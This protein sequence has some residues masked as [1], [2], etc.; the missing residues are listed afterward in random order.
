MKFK[1]VK[2]LESILLEYGMKSGS[3]TPSGQ[4]QTGANAKA[5]KIKSPTTSNAPKKP[6]QGSPTVGDK[7]VPEPIE[8]QQQSAKDIKKDAVI[9]GQDNKNKKVVSPVGQGDLPDAM[10]VQDDDGEYEIIDQNE[11]V[12]AL[13]PED[14]EKIGKDPSLLAKGKGAFGAGAGAVDKI[15]NLM[16]S[17]DPNVKEGKIRKRINKKALNKLKPR[18]RQEKGRVKK[19]ARLGLTEAIEK[20]FEINFRNKDVINSSLDAQIRCGW[21]A[22]TVWENIS[23]PSDDID[24]LTLNEVDDQFGG[25]DWDGIS[26]SYTEWLYDNKVEE[27][28]DDLIQ[29]FINEREDDEDYINEFIEDEGIEE[30]DWDDYREGVLRTE[31]GDERFEEEGAEELSELYGY[32]DENWAREYVDEY[33][34]SDFREYLRN[35]AEEDDD[36]KQAAYEEASENYDY[37][38]WVN[39]SYYSMSEFCDNWDIDY[40]SGG[41]LEEVADKLEDWITDNSAFHDH[42]PDTGSYGDTSGNTT[43]YAVET[44]SSIDGYGTGAEIISPVFSTPR[45]MLKEMD[46]FFKFL[47]SEGVV[48]NNS[49]GLHITMSYFPQEGETVSHEDGKIEANKVKMAVLLGDQY[50]LSQWGRDRNTYTKSQLKELQSAIQNLKR[51]GRGTEAIKEAEKFLAKH[52]SEDKFRSIHFKGQTDQ[53][54]NTKLIEFRIGGGEDYHEEFKKV[55]S[56]VVRYATTMIAG[57]TDQYQGDY[58]KALLRLMNNMDKI[59]TSDE[60]EVENLKSQHSDY[61]GHPILDTH[62]AIISAKNYLD[63]TQKMLNAMEDLHKASL[64]LDPKADKKWKKEWVDFLKGTGSNLD[65]YDSKIRKALDKIP[66]KKITE[67]KDRDDRSIKAYMQPETTPPSERAI[68][69]RK[70]GLRKFSEAMGMLSIDISKKTARSKPNAKSIGAFR[71][72]LKDYDI[73]EKELDLNV[74][75]I[76]NDVNLGPDLKNTHKTKLEAIR[77]GINTLLQKDVITRPDYA[78]SPQ[79]EAMAKGLWNAFNDEQ[80]DDKTR[81][82]LIRLVISMRTGDISQGSVDDKEVKRDVAILI[83]QAKDKREFNDFYNTIV[84][85]PTSGGHERFLSPG[86]IFSKPDFDKLITY[87]KGFESYTQPVNRYHNPNLY[88]DDSYEENS[89]S[90]YTLLLRRRFEYLENQFD[91]D[92]SLATQSLERMSKLVETFYQENQSGQFEWPDIFGID[93]DELRSD[94]PTDPRVKKMSYEEKDTI[95]D[96]YGDNDGTPFLGINSYKVERVQGVLDNIARGDIDRR[97]ISNMSEFVTDTIREALGAYYRNK[98]RY[99]EYYKFEEVKN[100]IKER[101]EG[102][103][104]FMRGIDK[105]FVDNGFD[106]QDEII[107]RKQQ[108]DKDA[109]E[110]AKMQANKPLATINL[111]S[112]ST[113][114]MDNDSYNWFEEY[115]QERENSDDV[116]APPDTARAVVKNII[117]GARNTNDNSGSLRGTRIYVV[118]AAHWGPLMDAVN[119]K[120]IIKLQQRVGNM[121]Q[122]WRLKNYKALLEAFA[123]NYS[124]NFEQLQKTDIFTVIDGTDRSKLSK[125]F[126]IQFTGKLDGR[127]GMGDVEDLIPRET[128][129][130]KY[131]GEPLDR[132]SAVAWSVNNDANDKK[133]FQAYDF[134]KYHGK[135]AEKIKQLVAKE[136]KDNDRSFSVAIQK[137]MERSPQGVMIIDNDRIAKAA[138]V[139]HMERDSSN[140]IQD[141]TNWGNLADFLKIERGVDNQGPNMLEKVSRTFDGDHDWRPEPDPNACC[142]ERWVAC[143]KHAAEYIKMNYTV[144]GGNYF[145]KENDGS[146][147]DDVGSIYGDSGSNPPPSRRGQASGPTISQLDNEEVTEQDYEKVRSNYIDFDRMMNAGMQNYMVRPDVNRLVAFLK[148]TDNDEDFKRAVLQSMMKE[149]LQGSE[150]NDFQGHLALGRQFYANQNTSEQDRRGRGR[151]GEGIQDVRARMLARERV[152]AEFD[153]LPLQEQLIIL[154]N[155]KVLERPLTKDE[156]KDKEKYVKG[157]KKNKKD[158]E[159]RYG[160][161]AEA[162]MYATATNMAKEDLDE[163]VPT[164]KTTKIIND[165]LADHFPVGD[166]KKQMLAFQA[167]PIP[168]MLNQFRELRGEAGDDACARGIVRYYVNALPKSQ[169]DQ[170]DLNEWAKSKVRSLIESKGIMG[171]VQGDTFLKGDDR[172]EF[173]SVT[174]YP[175]E[176]MQFNSPEQRDDFIQQL[177]QELN[178]QI[179]W[180]N[181]PN[182]GSLAFGVATLTDPALDDKITYWGR[183]F[184]QKTADMMG[185]WGN[186]QV[187][188]GWKLQT[189]GA[190]K[191]DIGIDPQH[192]IKTDDPFNGV[193]DVIQ[194][195]K[196]NSTG[197]ELSE[198]LVNALETIHTQEHPVFPGQ[199]SNL[200]ALRDYFG[201]IMG[202]VALMS[203]MV[204][205]QAEDARRDLL[206]GIPW[207][208]CSIFWPMAMNAP[209]VDSYFT[210]PDGT[211]VG[212]SSKGGK[213]AKASV[214]NIQD[215][216]LKAPEELK[217]QYPTTV[218]VINI[219]QS[220]SAKDGPFRLAELYNILPQGLEEEI[221][222]Y[223]QEGKQ[224]Y[225]GLSPACTELFNYGTPRQDVPGFNT[226]YAMLALLAK[227][228]TKAINT[229]GP[230]F[231]QGCVAFLNQSS[232]VQL[233]CKMGKQGDDARVTGWEAVYPPNFQGTVEIDGSKNYYSSRIGGK[234]AFGFK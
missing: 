177:E 2:T 69:R 126:G 211:R 207:S 5:N 118:P 151:D 45:R 141:A 30:S 76:L 61:A 116:D 77:N 133:Q 222:G 65:D 95:L 87:L 159:K 6:D 147:G 92:K 56:S 113:M 132:S 204:G 93:E 178:S 13:S 119:G 149:K 131:S 46:K 15:A 12:D 122:A 91:S 223:I 85:R 111:P 138:G 143:V 105:I 1:D 43:E 83:D 198:S 78:T 146:L 201:E 50:L 129:N 172:L 135:E 189:A 102:L 52:I 205:G 150:P 23:G 60:E 144:S 101:F 162:V 38:D 26:E 233:Y 57:H 187:P 99:P 176:E 88:N 186:N 168:Q 84:G 163:S 72:F 191:L 36:I 104:D 232:I 179:D 28:V 231:G 137:V 154:E 19:L 109:K 199:I 213:G 96:L 140:S 212:I 182:K 152:F 229:S 219:V 35:I 225:A 174:L 209:L 80:F 24:N 33:R 115:V 94:E 128:L 7:N 98:K 114:Y 164:I 173:Q 106:S 228:V 134:A 230:E 206:R 208:N 180:T 127:T 227:K 27:F 64:Y 139:E 169:Q 39:D 81:K 183:Y 160:K 47:Q 31:Y 184:K 175:T 14:A 153:K 54:T 17:K 66:G 29:D 74:R 4:Q 100:L 185:K 51:E 216:I 200:P 73:T 165:L 136:M 181:A 107:K 161:D 155:S 48:T 156:K 120:E 71:S 70:S 41:N 226:G 192:L 148:N 121:S 63:F 11:K 224:D 58:I 170:I 44:D 3:S 103:R 18:V 40:S 90:K 195:V 123:D 194:A 16:A 203:D 214:K 158:F 97:T 34:G 220:N 8:P 21:E 197:N 75:N 79:V 62:K 210:A 124:V 110:F 49:T 221:N 202:P 157:M 89:L 142:L 166:L 215:A 193:L 22:E 42:R 59:A 125:H 117:E 53:K 20:L 82:D 218:N 37:D 130:N 25:V 234:F 190:M 171:R 112:H 68:D 196:T 32:E 55:F 188:V 86:Q 10:V 217:A 108:I 145:R 67:D 167:I 9:V